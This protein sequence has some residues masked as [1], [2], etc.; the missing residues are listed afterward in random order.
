MKV[1]NIVALAILKEGEILLG[2]SVKEG[3]AFKFIGGKAEE[4]ESDIE[5]LKREVKEEVNVEVDDKSIKF[6]KEYEGVSWNDTQ[7]VIKVRLYLGDIIGEPVAS[8]EI[9]EVKYFD[10]S[11][12]SDLIL[13]VSRKFIPWLKERGFI[14]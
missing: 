10:S 5:C 3:G 14:N 2:R 8:R 9:V 12:E 11:V 7:L 6:L 13:G 1:I 4:N